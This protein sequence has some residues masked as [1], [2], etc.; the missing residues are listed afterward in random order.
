LRAREA[1]LAQRTAELEQARAA[2]K[3]ELA[4]M[5]GERDAARARIAELE[6]GRERL[7]AELEARTR[8]LA[9]ARAETERVRALVALRSDE[10]AAPLVATAPGAEQL[11]RRLDA[12][13]AQLAAL[14][15]ELAE[16]DRALQD[17]VARL[18]ALGR[19][20]A[21]LEAQREALLRRLEEA[22][23]PLPGEEVGR[24][25]EASARPVAPALRAAARAAVEREARGRAAILANLPGGDDIPFVQ[26]GRIVVETGLLF[27]SGRAELTASGRARL[28]AVALR[29]GQAIDSLPRDV[30]WVLRIDGHTD[31]LPVVRGR[32]RN[33]WELSA[34]RAAAVA[35]YLVELGFPRDRLMVAGFADARPLVPNRDEASRARNRRIEL[36]LTVG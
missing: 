1:E 11:Q 4:R 10:S 19:Q 13:A 30:P 29:L 25:I 27:E 26:D 12:Q 5:A 18:E 22:G 28:A 3:D 35:D 16:R 21:V 31:D 6:A 14:R 32:F 24:Q 36:T 20:A 17:T 2:A 8:E 15:Q 34:A 33:N 9:D 23:L 7:A